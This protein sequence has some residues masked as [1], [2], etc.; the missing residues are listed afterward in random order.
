MLFSQDGNIP[1]SS[2]GDTAV[3][4]WDVSIRITPHPLGCDRT[5]GRHDEALAVAFA[6]DGRTVVRVSEKRPLRMREDD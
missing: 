1:A 3:Q 6:S 4:L 2:T 5:G